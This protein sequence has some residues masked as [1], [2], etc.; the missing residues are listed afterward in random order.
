[1]VSSCCSGIPIPVSFTRKATTAPPR[2]TPSG[3]SSSAAGSTRSS[4]P[5]CSVNFT[6]LDSRL[7]RICRSR[8]SSVSRSAGAPAAVVTVNSRLLCAVMG[9]KVASTYSISCFSGTRSGVTSILPASTLDRSRMSLISWS[10][11]EPAEWM[12]P[13]YS[14]CFGVRLREGFWAS[15]WARMSRLLSGVRSSW[16]MLARNSD[17]YLEASD[18]CWARVSSS[19]RACSICRFFASMSRFCSASSEA[20]SS[21]SALDCCSSSCRACNS[22]ER[23]CSSLV[24][25]CDSWRSSSVRALATIVLTLTPMVSTSCCRKS[26]WVAVNRVTDASSMTPSS[27]SS[28]TMGSSSSAV[29]SIRPSPEEMVT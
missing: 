29:G 23:D 16:L 20:F 7:R 4:T 8:E 1:M 14:T 11:S 13:A 18:N 5:P 9:R 25:R 19:C 2:T 12:M 3:T 22:A 24:R 26:R 10:R 21:S 17:L 28:N 27:C 6:A 15:S